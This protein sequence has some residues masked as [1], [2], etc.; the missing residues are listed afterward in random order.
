MYIGSGMNTVSSLY[1]Q[2]QKEQKKNQMNLCR[3]FRLW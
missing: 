1:G 2:Q 3:S